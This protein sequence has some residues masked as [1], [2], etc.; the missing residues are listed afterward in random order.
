MLTAALTSACQGPYIPFW[1]C[2]WGCCVYM[3]VWERKRLPLREKMSSP[4]STNPILS[5][6]N[7][8]REHLPLCILLHAA[9]F[10][11]F[12]CTTATSLVA[13]LVW[14]PSLSHPYSSGLKR[15][16]K[17]SNAGKKVASKTRSNFSGVL[18]LS[19]AIWRL[20]FSCYHPHK[21]FGPLDNILLLLPLSSHNYSRIWNETVGQRA[22]LSSTEKGCSNN[23]NLKTCWMHFGILN[24]SS[25]I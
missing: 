3:R 1:L 17:K 7:I 4:N 22:S 23:I 10:H 11:V 13:I 2:L 12:S 20:S 25:S 9:S 16:A 24:G 14:I 8:F 15:G 19:S 6:L 21:S 18:H 5:V